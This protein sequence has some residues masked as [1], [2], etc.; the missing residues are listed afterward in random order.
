[1]VLHQFMPCTCVFQWEQHVCDKVSL[2]S[3]DVWSDHLTVGGRTSD[4]AGQGTVW[5]QQS[6]GG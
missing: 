1:M 6:P 5:I 3:E 2:Y 4:T